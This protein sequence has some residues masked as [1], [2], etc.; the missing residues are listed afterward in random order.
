MIQHIKE[1]G[2]IIAQINNKTISLGYIKHNGTELRF[3]VKRNPKYHLMRNLNAWG[4]NA[5]LLDGILSNVNSLVV[6][7]SNN[8]EYRLD[9][10]KLF[11]ILARFNVHYWNNL[12]KQIM[13]PVELFDRF[14]S[15]GQFV[16]GY[17]IDE[18]SRSC[19]SLWKIRHKNKKQLSL[20]F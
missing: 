16:K 5:E 18:F 12:E 11:D 9:M 3:I 7:I 15:S 10:N 13:I 6:K 1:T 19:N 14:C 17:S 8:V 20:P 2:E 4:F